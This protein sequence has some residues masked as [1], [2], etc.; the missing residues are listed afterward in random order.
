MDEMTQQNAALVEQ[1]AAS[2][3]SLR[4]QSS[5]LSQ[6][7]SSFQ[8]SEKL[9]NSSSS[10]TTHNE[11]PKHQRAYS[12]QPKQLKPQSPSPEDEWESF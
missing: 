1:A 9:L 10:H 8:L 12:M 2:S 3:E 6:S 7:I 4:G 5:M 11:Q